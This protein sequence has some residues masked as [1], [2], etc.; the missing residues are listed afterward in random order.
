MHQLEPYFNWRDR[1]RSED[2]GASPFYGR[3]YDEF[4]FS[5][6]IYNYYI[7]PQWD[8]IGSPTL[9]IKILFADYEQGFAIIELIGEWN[10]AI[11]ND[12]MFLKR[13]IIDVLIPEGINKFI[14]IGENVLNFHGSDD[15]Y[16][17][18][19]MEDIQDAEGWVILS[20]FQQHVVE[21]MREHCIHYHFFVGEQYDLSEW[22]K[23]KPEAI[24][25]MLD[26]RLLKSLN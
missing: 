19:W 10:D 23:H 5:T 13:E 2:D 24:L 16:Y 3:E 18:E 12:I 9:Y 15:C 25:Q 26:A 20:N 4:S 11:N 22:R 8:H 14:L 21:E 1:Y 7:H 6:K 17:E